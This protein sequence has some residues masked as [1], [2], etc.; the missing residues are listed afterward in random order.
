MLLAIGY[1]H[2][3]KDIICIGHRGETGN[4]DV[5][6]S[7]WG[8]D[9][10][11]LLE[12]VV[13]KYMTDSFFFDTQAGKASLEFVKEDRILDGMLWILSDFGQA[14]RYYYLNV[15]TSKD[16]KENWSLESAEQRCASFEINLYKEYLGPNW[17]ELF[18]KQSPKEDPF[19]VSAPMLVKTFY[20]FNEALAWTFKQGH[21]DKDVEFLVVELN[22]L[23]LN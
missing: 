2:M 19:K 11:Y 20:R 22:E 15:V 4:F 9:L 7:K 16:P 6:L 21:L 13:S 12:T 3:M 8:H 17:Q 14:D 18:A 23:P 5:T 1:E 10:K